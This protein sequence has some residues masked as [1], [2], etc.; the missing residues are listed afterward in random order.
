LV[1]VSLTHIAVAHIL[2]P[3]HGAIPH[4][5]AALWWELP[6]CVMECARPICP[7]EVMP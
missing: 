7:C 1:L 2:R 6:I 3:V 5:G 4:S